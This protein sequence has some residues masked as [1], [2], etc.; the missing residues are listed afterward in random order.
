VVP[1]EKGLHKREGVW[2]EN[3]AAFLRPVLLELFQVSQEDIVDCLRVQARVCWHVRA[4]IGRVG[5]NNKHKAALCAA[6]NV[7]H[8]AE[9]I[10]AATTKE[11]LDINHRRGGLSPSATNSLLSEHYVEELAAVLTRPGPRQ[12][13]DEE[14]HEELRLHA[15]CARQIKRE[16]LAGGPEPAAWHVE[17]PSD[18]RA[19]ELWL[20]NTLLYFAVTPVKTLITIPTGNLPGLPAFVDED[21]HFLPAFTDERLYQQFWLDHPD[22]TARLRKFGRQVLAVLRKQ[23]GLGLAVNQLANGTQDGWYWTAKELRDL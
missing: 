8:D 18:Q 5:R 16:R 15:E 23:G 13:T 11:R 22:P 20:P 6:F 12:P 10:Q 17:S 2:R 7:E 3:L 9:I 4:A 21:Q 14:F 1:P 19:A